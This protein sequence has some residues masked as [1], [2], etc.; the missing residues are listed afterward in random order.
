MS[1]S[2]EPQPAT[3]QATRTSFHA[4]LDP[5]QMALASALAVIGSLVARVLFGIATPAEIFGDQFTVLVPPPVF[6]FFLRTFGGAT[7]HLYFIGLLFGVALLLWAVTLLYFRLLDALETGS[8]LRATR[9]VALRPWPTW[10]QLLALV[11]GLWVLAAGVLAPLIGGG[12]LGAALANGAG[13]VFVSLLVMDG[14]FALFLLFLAPTEV[15]SVDVS[16]SEVSRRRMGRR[17]LLRQGGLAVGILA[18]GAIGWE[19]F[20]DT[21]NTVLG[22][23][24][25]SARYPLP[26][27]PIPGPISPPP[28]PTYTT[29]SRTPGQTSEVTPTSTFYYVSKNVASD[30]VI[31]GQTWTLTVEGLVS[32]P[33]TLSLGDLRGS[34]QTQRYQTLECISNEVGG[35]LMSNAYWTGVSIASL[36]ERAGPL[37]TAAELVFTCADGY[38]DRLHLGQAL[39]PRALVVYQING[40][41]LPIAHGYPARLLVP[42]LYGMKNGKWLTKLTLGPGGYT[43]YWEQRGWSREAVVKLMARIDTPRNQD[44]LAAGPVSIAGVA[45]AGVEGIAQV[46]VS[47]D[48]GRTWQVAN[49]R[50]PLGSL[51]WVLWEYSWQATPGAHVLVVRAVD[52]RGNV[53]TPATEPPIPNGATGYDAIAVTVR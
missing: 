20:S 43:G 13:G 1:I 41:S 6:D 3:P 34:P 11:T 25:S 12:W 18:V 15:T 2:G 35:D 8:V 14:L 52:L 47:L 39:D 32:T 29:W 53:Q 31:N 51:T 24:T 49:L 37:P 44:L 42:G 10:A 9:A 26:S 46:Q 17:A 21:L 4:R 30:P 36:L 40:E 33:Y 45:F 23:G 50:R 27:L 16:T 19:F 38:S 22:L 48:A 28:M 5:G 7:K